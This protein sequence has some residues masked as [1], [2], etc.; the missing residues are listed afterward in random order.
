MASLRLVGEDAEVEAVLEALRGAVRVTDV[1]GP[2][3]SRKTQGH[4]LVYAHVE[5]L[6]PA[7]QPRRR[8]A[9]VRPRSA[10]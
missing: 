4:V 6:L 5:T 8:A 7:E 2:S 3:P 10:R 9:S 1:T